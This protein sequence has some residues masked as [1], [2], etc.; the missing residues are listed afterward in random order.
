[1]QGMSVMWYC[2]SILFGSYLPEY[3]AIKVHQSVIQDRYVWIARGA[4]TSELLVSSTFSDRCTSYLLYKTIS[5]VH[6][7]EDGICSFVRFSC[8]AGFHISL[9]SVHSIS[10]HRLVVKIWFLRS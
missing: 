9:L 2:N 10:N 4:T 1:M 8:F 5:G 7:S 6:S 3:P